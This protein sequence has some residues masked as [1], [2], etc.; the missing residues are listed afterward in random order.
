ML[1]IHQQLFSFCS[2]YASNSIFIHPQTLLQIFNNC[3]SFARSRSHNFERSSTTS[4]Q[5]LNKCS[6][7]LQQMVSF[8]KALSLTTLFPE[9]DMALF[10]VCQSYARHLFKICL[11]IVGEWVNPNVGWTGVAGSSML[12]TCLT[13]AE[14]MVDSLRNLV[15]QCAATWCAPTYA[16]RRE[17]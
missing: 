4:K 5:I 16:D 12:N 1:S 10:A 9:R 6:T 2:L 8:V 13:F 17:W 3:S 14:L 15:Q 7:C 11:T